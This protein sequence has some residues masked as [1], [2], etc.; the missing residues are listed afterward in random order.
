M[1]YALGMDGFRE[2]VGALAGQY[3][4]WAPVLKVGEGRFT[5]TD[6]VRYDFVTSADEIEWHTRSDY[7]FKEILTPLSQTLFYF[8]DGQTTVPPADTRDVLVFLRACDLCALRRL[9]QVYQQSGPRSDW[10]YD[11]IRDHVRFALIG[12][13]ESQEDCFCV[14][15]GSNVAPAGSY[16]LSVDFVAGTD[17]E[18]QVLMD[19]PAADLAALVAPRATAER[20]VEPA[21]V[22]EN[23]TKVTVPA[24]VPNSIYKSDIWAEYN[25][26]CIEC[27]RCNFVCPTCTCYTMQ[28]VFYT[29]NGKVGERRRVAASCMVDGYTN[30]AGGGQYRRTAGDRMR[31]KV[32]HK[33][34]D[35]RRRFGYD[36]CVGCGRCTTVCP[37]YIN[38]AAAVNKLADACAAEAAAATATKEGAGA[39]A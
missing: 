36:M 15:M 18:P 20:D 30:V 21:H 2:V 9:D 39:N 6:V 37:E 26:R 8:T 35:F 31:F 12:C 25:A 19:V 17:G 11:R 23:E 3:R 4:L 27:G 28:D 16:D 22:T 34:Y 32:L 33:V 24:E 38:F 5:D 14:S 29:D 1:G 7:A 13:P 10:F